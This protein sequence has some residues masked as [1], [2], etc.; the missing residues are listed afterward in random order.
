MASGNVSLQSGNNAM[1]LLI[2][3]DENWFNSIENLYT[4]GFIGYA[5]YWSLCPQNKPV[6]LKDGDPIYIYTQTPV[7]DCILVKAKGIFKSR[8]FDVNTGILNFDSKRIMT[9][10]QSYELYGPSNGSVSY[11]GYLNLLQNYANV[12]EKGKTIDDDYEIGVTIIT[13][14]DFTPQNYQLVNGTNNACGFRY[15]SDVQGYKI[16]LR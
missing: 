12:N 1:G 10:R 5:N 16:R 14:L 6:N 3:S 9:I 4:K 2:K 8:I 11:G 7:E 13:D 15:I